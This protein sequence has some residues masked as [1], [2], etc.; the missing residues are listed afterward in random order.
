L[1]IKLKGPPFD[2]A[3]VFEAESQAVLNTLPEQNFQ[4]AFKKWQKCWERCMLR[5]SYDSILNY[6]MTM[7]FNSL[8]NNNLIIFCYTYISGH[9]HPSS[10]HLILYNNQ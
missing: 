5:T 6:C 3:E 10:P 8:F 7:L 9:Y 4:D 1:K 2:T